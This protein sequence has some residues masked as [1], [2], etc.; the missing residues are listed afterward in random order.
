MQI[1]QDFFKMM[2]F[3]VACRKIRTYL[4][5]LAIDALQVA[6]A[7]ENIGDAMKPADRRLFAPVCHNGTDGVFVARSAI[8]AVACKP[9]GPAIARTKGT[10]CQGFKRDIH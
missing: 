3:A 8:A 7:E 4:K 6:V 1:G 2:I 10:S 9:V 5:I